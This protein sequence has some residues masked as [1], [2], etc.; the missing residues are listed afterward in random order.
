MK[1]ELIQDVAEGGRSLKDACAAA[2][3]FGLSKKAPNYPQLK[4][5]TSKRGR[6]EYV[7][8]SIVEMTAEGAKKWIDR[9]LAKAV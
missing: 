6:I 2:D 3:G 9:G 5:T 4:V 1:V 8:G 7:K